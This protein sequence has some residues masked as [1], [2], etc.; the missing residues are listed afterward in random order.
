MTVS[1]TSNRISYNGDASSTVFSFPYKFLA[2]SDLKVYVGDVLQTITTDYS[3]GTPSDTGAN[4]TFVSPPAAGTDNIVIVRDSDLLQQ[5]ALK[6]NG[7][8]PAETVEDMVD[9]VTLIAQRIRDLLTRSF[10]LSDSDTTG[11]SLT[12]PTPAAN[13]AI[14]WSSDGLSLVNSTYDPD[15]AV[16]DASA[17]AT[18]AENSAISAAASEAG[19]LGY[20]QTFQGQYYGDLSAD[21]TLDPLGNPIGEGDLYW[22]TS[23]LALRIYNGTAWQ[24]TAT[25]TSAS[26]T[27]DTFSGTGA[28]TAF[29]LS[30]TP[31]SVQSLIVFISGVR[32]TPTT[33]YT[34]SGTT[35]NFVA[36]PPLGTGNITTLVVS[37]LAAGTP[38]ND[39]VST[40]KLQDGAVTTSK[41]ENDA[42]TEEKIADSAVAEFKS[43]SI[44]DFDASVA[45]NALTLTI[46]AGIWDFRSTTLTDG[47]PITRTLSSPV[48]V[49]VPSG[50]TLGTV[51]TISARLAVV[52]IDN[53]GTLEA[54]VVNLAGGNQLDET[55]L[56]TTTTIGTG[57]DSNNVI[58]S[59]TGRTSVA[60]RVIGFIDITEATAG[61]WAT[62][63][64]LVQGCGGQALAALSSLGYGQTWQV[65]TRTSGTTYY[66]TTGKPLQ[67]SV[68]AV[69]TSASILVNGQG[70][71]APATTQAV[72]Y[73]FI[74]PQNQSYV[75]TNSNALTVAE[76]R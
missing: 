69:W 4:V 35:L 43:K 70:I 58:Y 47:T 6:S 61:T 51:N 48:S 68:T 28:Q 65:V 54:A 56:I 5:A 24:N 36:A 34:F 16:A 45:A 57:S 12:V 21:P 41:I 9:K 8:F 10:T 66:N 27:A 22:N 26:F 29:T 52:L 73:T 49:V 44:S 53:S 1:T 30:A 25:A 76:L 63:P 31:A 14:K 75:I 13:R 20:L 74:V 60:Y 38:D 15:E 3:V 72:G 64:T 40:D 37:A 42:V 7:K 33:D 23:S 19:A 62:A 18:A 2:T 67:C 71:S 50:A 59:T 32:Q 55:N 11:A 39:S 46:N 17:F